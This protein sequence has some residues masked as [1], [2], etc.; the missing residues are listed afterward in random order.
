MYIH[1]NAYIVVFAACFS[2]KSVAIIDTMQHDNKEP[3]PI[4]PT[5]KITRQGELLTPIVFGGAPH[6]HIHVYV[7]NCFSL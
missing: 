1:T 6:T 2:D 5:N 3:T 7:L 4:V